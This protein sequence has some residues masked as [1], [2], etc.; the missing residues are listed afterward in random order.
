M[1]TNQK[2]GTQGNSEELGGTQELASG[3]R[4]QIQAALTHH[5]SLVTPLEFPRVP[6]IGPAMASSHEFPSSDSHLAYLTLVYTISGGRD[7]DQLWPAAFATYTAD[8]QLFDPQY[9]AWAKPAALLPSLRAHGLS[10]KKSEATVWQR[11][12]QALVM[13]AGGSV[14]K[15]LADHDYDAYKLMA[16]LAKSKTIFP[17][18]SGPQT[19]PRWL[20]GLATLGEQPIS[21]AAD[22]PVPVSPA[23]TRALTSL[24]LEADVVPADLFEELDGIGR[25]L[26]K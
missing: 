26:Q 8:P 11:V 21:H 3:L 12:G 14:Q 19:A 20:Y 13:R 9:L 23:V 6:A 22:L 10:R 7:P 1:N 25:S 16:M 2:M 5:S 17:I 18:L 4:E 24:N 15:L